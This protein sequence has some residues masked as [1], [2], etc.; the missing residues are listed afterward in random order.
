MND[1]TMLLALIVVV[2]AMIRAWYVFR[3]HSRSMAAAAAAPDATEQTAGLDESILA[4]YPRLLYSQVK[5][6]YSGSNATAGSSCCSICLADYKEDELVLLLPN[7]AHFFHLSCVGQ[8]L[9]AHPT[10]PVCRNSL[11]TASQLGPNCQPISESLG[12]RQIHSVS[13]D[14]V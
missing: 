10:C 8:W 1:V 5:Q 7:C 2:L 13:D 4:T 6:R 9:R 11:L 12:S 14:V 3:A